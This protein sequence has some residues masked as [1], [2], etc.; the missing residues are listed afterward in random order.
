MKKQRGITLIALVITIVVLIILAGVAIN[1]TIGENGIFTRAEEAK[2]QYEIA[3]AEEELDLKIA[4][5]QIEKQG[6]ATLQDVVDMLKNET[7]MD[8]VVSLEEIA[9]VTGVEVIGEVEEIYVVY[10]IYQFKINNT[11][12]TEFISIID[13]KD[14]D[15]DDEEEVTD[16]NSTIIGNVTF[17]IVELNATSM[18]LQV[19]VETDN[20]EDIK[21]YFVYVNQEV[22]HIGEENNILVENLQ[23]GTTYNIKCGV[24]DKEGKIKLSDEK[25]VT[26]KK[27]IYD[28][29]N[30]SNGVTSFTPFRVDT[31]PAYGAYG[32][33]NGYY[34]ISVGDAPRYNNGVLN[35]LDALRVNDI[36][37]IK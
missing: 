9:S 35:E 16:K 26:T 18:K 17:E 25:T 12:E 30:F 36:K 11:L 27:N 34:Q 33:A 24:I 13:H 21:G 29:T 31:A 6:S 28:G 22:V 5:L 19:N 37:E 32:Q 10:K 23:N 3:Q 8:Y 7:D 14:D 15:A 20:T 4:K 2:L 1:L